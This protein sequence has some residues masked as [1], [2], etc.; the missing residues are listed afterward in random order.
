MREPYGFRLRWR[1]GNLSLGCCGSLGPDRWA[2]LPEWL[3][4]GLLRAPGAFTVIPRC[5]PLDLVRLW[6]GSPRCPTPTDPPYEQ[7]CWTAFQ[8]RRLGGGLCAGTFTL[9]S[10]AA[11]SCEGW[12]PVLSERPYTG[13]VTEPCQQGVVSGPSCMITCVGDA[14]HITRAAAQPLTTAVGRGCDTRWI[15]ACLRADESAC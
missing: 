13:N 15:L 7:A 5:S 10:W 4:R 11:V 1:I 14:L 12:N 9:H 3:V 8:R 6:C 2:D